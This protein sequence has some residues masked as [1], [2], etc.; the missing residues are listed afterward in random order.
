MQVAPCKNCPN[1]RV[2][3]H[4]EAV[5]SKWAEFEEYKKKVYARRKKESDLI[6]IDRNRPKKNY[7]PIAS[8]GFGRR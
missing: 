2:G 5:C 7:K 8:R 1:R 4:S 6:A 3:C